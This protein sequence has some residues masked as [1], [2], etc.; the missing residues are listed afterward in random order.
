MESRI[1][2]LTS[3]L[4]VYSRLGLDLHFRTFFISNVFI[5]RSSDPEKLRIFLKN[6]LSTSISF[7]RNNTSN[8][9]LFLYINLHRER[10]HYKM[11]HMIHKL[12]TQNKSTNK[13]EKAR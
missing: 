7:K 4:Q 5:Q 12:K 11:E 8:R 10:I 6:S 1:V 13:G 2:V 3:V 9:P